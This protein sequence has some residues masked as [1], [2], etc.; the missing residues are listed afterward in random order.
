MITKKCEECPAF[1]ICSVKISAKVNFYGKY[2]LEFN[3]KIGRTMDLNIIIQQLYKEDN[4]NIPYPIYK[5]AISMIFENTIDIYYCL[6][7]SMINVKGKYI[8]RIE[9]IHEYIYSN[10]ILY[11]RIKE[12]TNDKM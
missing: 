10:K 1:E 7:P 2:C 9:Y 11:N 6:L 4:T 3:K 12:F 5:K 8:K